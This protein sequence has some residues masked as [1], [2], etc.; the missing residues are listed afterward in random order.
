[1]KGLHNIIEIFVQELRR[2][3]FDEGVLVF[4][5]I[6]PIIYPVLYSFLYGNEVVREVPTVVVDNCN[7][8]LS[9][10]FL[11]KVD[12]THDV[13][14]IGHCA[15]MREA[16]ELI[17][18]RKA[19]GLIYIP[20]EFEKRIIDLQQST[21]EVYSD[22]S[23]ILYYKAVYSSCTDVSLAMNKEIKAQRMPGATEQQISTFQ[24]PIEY[25]YTP[26]FN[27]QSGFATFMIPGILMLVIQQTMLLGVGMLA[28]DERENRRKG[29]YFDY[30]VNKYPIEIITGKSLAYFMF[31]M[32]MSVYLCCIV[33]QL[34][35]L[36]HIWKWKELLILMISYVAACT[37]FCI[38]LSFA[39]HDREVFIIL[40][41]FMSVP[42]IFMSGISWPTCAMPKFWRCFAWLFPSTFGV[43][44][45]LKVNNMGV[46]MPEVFRDIWSLWLQIAGYF[47]LAYIVCKR[48]Y[49]KKY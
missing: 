31:Y 46:S 25:K 32:L 23:G 4:F 21:I 27:T 17:H 13:K 24:Y 26:L 47:T 36:I 49:S 6:V 29:I 43:K 9:R 7:S 44:G 28:G 22:M 18:R 39:A 14:I 37:F 2:T 41:I 20:R 40:F 42:L 19:Y 16:V 48:T 15:D 35:G 30:L 11:R 33:P 5:L 12:A 10:E 34:F 3:L 8:Q 45:F 38:T 1:M